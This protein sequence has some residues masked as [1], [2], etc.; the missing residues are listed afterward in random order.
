MVAPA[1]NA[2]VADAAAHFHHLILLHA[3]SVLVE[4]NAHGNSL[5]YA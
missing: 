3:E 4:L 5:K 2:G 1:L